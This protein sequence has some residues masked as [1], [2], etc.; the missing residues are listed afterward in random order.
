MASSGTY[1]YNASAANLTLVAFSRIGIRRTEITSQHMT[2]AANEANLVQVQMANRQPNL[3][4]DELYQVPLVAGQAT[5]DLPARMI[6]IQNAYIT[7]DYGNGTA[8]DRVIWPL[9]VF[10]Y[11]SVPDKNQQGVSTSYWYNRQI[12]PQ[13][14][15][16][17]VPDSSAN[18]TLNFRICS[19]IQDAVLPGG[20][21]LNMP[22]R[23][24]D[25]FVAELAYRMARIYAPDKE[26][27]RK[28]DAKE[29]TDWA[30]QE[31]QENVPTYV[32]PTLA[33]YY[34]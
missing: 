1:D 30:L 32:I 29:A 15:L 31:D 21:T 2:D 4:T 28:Q 7:I 20:V 24:L 27:M 9:S 18:Y 34:R 13:I 19:Q 6:A 12:V 14:S 26:V 16:W 25:A 22:Y 33:G 5:Y 3:W 8:T 17:P 10:E 23:W 11:S